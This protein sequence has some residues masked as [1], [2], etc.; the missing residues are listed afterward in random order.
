M[1]T[2]LPRKSFGVCG[3]EL[4]HSVAAAAG[5][6]MSPLFAGV[7]FGGSAMAAE[8]TKSGAIAFHDSFIVLAPRPAH[9]TAENSS[10][11]S[12]FYDRVGKGMRLRQ[13]V[14]DAARRAIVSTA[15]TDC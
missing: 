6:E 12:H 8:A 10:V 4:S 15:S 13:I 9:L 3:E 2:T 1:R 14:A 7:V 5:M 11:P